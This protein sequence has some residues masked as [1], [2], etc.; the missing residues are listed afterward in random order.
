MKITSLPA[1][2][3]LCLICASPVFAAA[4]AEIAQAI[5]SRLDAHRQGDAVRWGSFVD[6]DCL[7]AGETKADILKAIANRPSTVRSWFVDR[8]DIPVRF[9]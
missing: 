8:G 6:D 7:C 5:R 2:L 3:T 9:H 1:I 4:D